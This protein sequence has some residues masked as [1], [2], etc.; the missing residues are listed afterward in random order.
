MQ[1]SSERIYVV[2]DDPGHTHLMIKSLRRSGISN[3]ID[4]FHGGAEV[5]E[6]MQNDT[7]ESQ[8]LLLL[9]DLNMPG[10]SGQRVLKELKSQDC[11]KDVPVM[12]L[13]TTDDADEVKE[14]YH[15]GCNFFM[16]KPMHYEEFTD[17]VKNLGLRFQIVAEPEN[18]N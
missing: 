7:K 18:N 2:D 16:T 15:L 14:C 5:L 12:I 10:I 4:V 9:L 6:K 1:S 11:T 8:P 17:N 3:G 13:T